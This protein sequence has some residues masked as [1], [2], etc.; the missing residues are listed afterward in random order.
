[1]I[2]FISSVFVLV[3]VF[4]IFK[5]ALNKVF[6]LGPLYFIRRDN[7]TK[8][9]PLICKAF[10]HEISHPWRRGKGIQVRIRSQVLQVG[11]CKKYPDQREDE[12]VLSAIGGRYMDTEVKDIREW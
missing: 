9:T 4:T 8:G 3:V 12:G 2:I 7:G 10:M 1:M 11:V 6:P 5:T